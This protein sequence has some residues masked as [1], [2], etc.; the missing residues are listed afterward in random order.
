VPHTRA[1]KKK[2]PHITVVWGGYFPTSHSEVCLRD[3]AI[4]YVVRSQGENTIL[5]LLDVLENGGDLT[6][7]DGLSYREN[8]EF[9]HNRNRKLMDI[10]E[11]PVLPYEKIPVARYV[12]P[13]MLGSRTLS[14]HSSQGCPFTCSF[15]AVTKNYFG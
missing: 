12:K 14:Y 7:I 13:T 1:V 8:G 3:E 15:C 6:K 5:E 11:F 10:N 4:D 2:F 9:K